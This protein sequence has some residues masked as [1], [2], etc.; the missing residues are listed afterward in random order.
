MNDHDT[1]WRCG[2]WRPPAFDDHVGHVRNIQTVWAP[3]A[4]VAVL[5]Y[6][7]AM[8]MRGFRLA[9]HVAIG[10][11]PSWTE[12]PWEYWRVTALGGDDYVATRTT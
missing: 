5:R 6:A 3:S 4:D 10:V 2:I 8:A 7:A 12:Q 11:R 9:P 1:E